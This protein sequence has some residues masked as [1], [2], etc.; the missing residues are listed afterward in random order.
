MGLQNVTDVLMSF[1]RT[2]IR[3]YLSLD[4]AFVICSH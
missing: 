3:M 2:E 4:D 1:E